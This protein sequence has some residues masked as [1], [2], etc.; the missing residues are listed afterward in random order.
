MIAWNSQTTL[1]KGSLWPILLE[2]KEIPTSG[3]PLLLLYWSFSISKYYITKHHRQ[4]ENYI[5]A[6]Q[7]SWNIYLWQLS[8]LCIKG[9]SERYKVLWVYPCKEAERAVQNMKRLIDKCSDPHLA[10][11]V[12]HST[13]LEQGHST[14]QLLMSQKPAYDGICT[15]LQA[16]TGGTCIT[17]SEQEGLWTQAEEERELWFTSWSSW[18]PWLLVTKFTFHKCLMVRCAGTK[19][20]STPCP[21]KW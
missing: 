14:M 11:L 6:F 16:E 4:S 19:D 13:S 9:L 10:L 1:A 2:R 3:R 8:K 21:K 5:Q 12:Y 17:A 7:G 15:S 18:L 20:M